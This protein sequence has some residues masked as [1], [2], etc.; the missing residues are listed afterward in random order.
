MPD[1]EFT[2]DSLYSITPSADGGEATRRAT[3]YTY[4]ANGFYVETASGDIIKIVRLTA[5]EM[6]AVQ[7]LRNTAGVDDVT[8]YCVYRR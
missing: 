7:P 5:D 6:V 1:Y 4:R 8:V 2:A 3:A